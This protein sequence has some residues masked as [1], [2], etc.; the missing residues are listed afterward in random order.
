MDMGYLISK[1][2]LRLSVVLK[3]A[4]AGILMM[5]FAVDGFAWGQMGHDVTCAV[6]QKH[7]SKKAA[8]RVNEIFDGRSLVYWANWMD[9]ASHTP[10]FAYTSTWHYKNIDADE[11]FDN[12]V[13]NPNGDVITA[14]ESQIAALRSG[15][16]NKFQEALALK[17]VIHFMGDLHCPMHMGHK[18]DRGGNKWQV[19]WFRNGRNLHSIWDSGVIESAHKWTYSEWAN[20]IDCVSKAEM[21]AIC[22]GTLQD[23]GRETYEY[24]TKIYE[25]T[26]AGSKLS[27]DYVS[28]WAPVVEQQLERGGLRLAAVLNEIFK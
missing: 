3:S 4:W 15:K 2:A 22:G 6:A 27:Y 17:M 7:L 25:G 26:P 24:A 1:K 10:E 20:E 8:K 12:A 13:V 16:L 11:T 5:V 19:Q 21:A 14:L 23:W 9:N 28:E 18:S